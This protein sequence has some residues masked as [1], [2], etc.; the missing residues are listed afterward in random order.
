MISGVWAGVWCVMAW[1]VMCVVVSV[2]VIWCPR[3]S[4]Y[5][6]CVGSAC[7]FPSAIAHCHAHFTSH[8]PCPPNLP[9]RRTCPPPLQMLSVPPYPA[10]PSNREKLTVPLLPLGSLNATIPPIA[11][12]SPLLP[13]SRHT[14][15]KR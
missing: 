10:C 7:V 6:E 5:I 11:T 12:S 9:A 14:F 8:S 3:A 1:S 13:P 2:V 4:G 15:I